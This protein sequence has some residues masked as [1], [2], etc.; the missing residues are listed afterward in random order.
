[1]RE[2]SNGSKCEAACVDCGKRVHATHRIETVSL[3]E[4]L[5]EIENVLVVVCD[6]CSG[7]C[8]IPYKSLAPIQDANDRLIKSKA[9]SS[10]GEITLE[11][12]SQVDARIKLK[13]KSEPDFPHEYPLQ[14]IG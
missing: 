10:F 2:H 1:M 14:A 13:Q 11:L 9:V 7:I 8:S 3:C 12:K 5:E 4:G 6:E